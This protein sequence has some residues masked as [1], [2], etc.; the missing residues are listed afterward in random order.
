MSADDIFTITY[1]NQTRLII[2]IGEPNSGKTTL[3]ASIHDGFQKGP[4]GGYLFAGSKTLIGFEKRCHHARMASNRLSADTERTKSNDFSFLHLII[5]PEEPKSSR[6]SLLLA[7]VSGER[8]QLARDYTDEM[9]RLDALKRAN[10]LFYV[11]DGDHLSN[12]ALRFAAKENII[13]FI[14]RARQTGMISQK[15]GL[16]ILISKWDIVLQ[17]SGEQKLQE[18]FIKPIQNRFADI[19]KSIEPIAVRASSASDLS[20]R[21]GLSSFLQ[22]CVRQGTQEH[23]DVFTP[24]LDLN[25]REFLKLHIA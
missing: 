18:F 4:I 12:S 15:V 24:H 6:I 9:L 19:I 25:S 23:L 11:S 7:D 22:A 5:R 21:Y 14:E 20:P 2:V 17:R 10:E 13:K 8:F 1:E 3:L 16:H